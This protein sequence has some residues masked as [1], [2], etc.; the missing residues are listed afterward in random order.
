[1]IVENNSLC[2]NSSFANDVISNKVLSEN[3]DHFLRK[4]SENNVARFNQLTTVSQDVT[5]INNLSL[6]DNPRSSGQQIGSIGNSR[7]E[8]PSNAQLLYEK[9]KWR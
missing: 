5:K 9:N 3:A 7:E 2:D 4:S 6:S 8:S 1:M